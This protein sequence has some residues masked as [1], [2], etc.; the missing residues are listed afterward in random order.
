MVDLT[1]KEVVKKLV[2]ACVRGE[3]RSQELFY[4]TF[5]GK[6]LAVCMRYSRNREE[7]QDILH[8]GMIKVF[9]KLG[10]FENKGSLEGWVRR[11]IVNNAIDFVRTRKDFYLREEQDYLIDDM[12]DETPNEKEL[13]KV[14]EMKVEKL[15][16]LIQKLS[17]AYQMVFNLYAIENMTH[18]EI[19]DKLNINIGTSK[20]NLAKA[21]I[22]LKEL[23]EEHWNEFN[24]E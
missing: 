19:A 9:V 4:K 7:A 15:I 13:E 16:G 23:V 3:R 20:S 22:R 10:S 12:V 11:I 21:K 6:M 5:Y 14:R 24:Y 1:N 18:K 8:D 2:E 17:P